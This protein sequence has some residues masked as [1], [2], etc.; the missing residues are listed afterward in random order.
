MNMIPASPRHIPVLILLSVLLMAAADALAQTYSVESFRRLPNDVSAFIEPIKDLNGDD[1][2]LVK[3]EAPADFVFSS[4][5]G[6]VKRIDNVGEIWLYMPKGSKRLTFKHPQ[7]GVLRNYSF[8]EKLESHMTYEIRLNLP[9]LSQAVT[10]LPPD[11]VFTTLRD[12]LIV[13]RTDTLRIPEIPRFRPR[14]T[15][16]VLPTIGVGGGSGTF[17]VAGGVRAMLLKRHV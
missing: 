15:L 12:T 13:V 10:V 2:A 8:P 6:I 1:C 17:S 3:V 7:W 11:T 5:L 14:L 16:R 4:P 9:E